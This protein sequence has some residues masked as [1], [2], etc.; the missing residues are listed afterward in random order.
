[1]YRAYARMTRAGGESGAA[2]TTVLVSHRFSTVR[3]ADVIVVMD[4]GRVAE[5]G[6]H[7]ELLDAGGLYARTYRTQARGYR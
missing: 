7:E 2:P 6:S 1:M 3:T 4:R 5:Y